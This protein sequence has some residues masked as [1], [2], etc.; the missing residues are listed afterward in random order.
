MIGD[1]LYYNLLRHILVSFCVKWLANVDNFTEAYNR[2]TLFM[3]HLSSG[4]TVDDIKA[5]SKEVMDVRLRVKSYP[6]KKKI[7]QLGYVG[8]SN[9]VSAS[10]WC[11]LVIC[12]H[13]TLNCGCRI[14][15]CVCSC[16]RTQH[17]TLF[18]DQDAMNLLYLP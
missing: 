13:V 15:H 14:L 11:V 4:V 2:R 7:N 3:K 8:F 1:E 6:H 10:R 16:G 9:D 12:N 18:I 5:L 17:V